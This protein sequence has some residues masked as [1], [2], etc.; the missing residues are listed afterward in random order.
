MHTTCMHACTH[1]MHTLTKMA[2]S[3]P[4]NRWNSIWEEYLEWH[5]KKKVLFDNE[6]V[7]MMNDF[8]WSSMWYYLE[9]RGGERERIIS[10][11]TGARNE[12]WRLGLRLALGRID[13]VE[14]VVV[15]T[16]EDQERAGVGTSG[17]GCQLTTNIYFIWSPDL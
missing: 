5:F 4:M 12:C 8:R 9:E 11:S 15:V 3:I 13:S 2:A 1:N 17:I 7:Q 16:A 14:M 6:C 10:K